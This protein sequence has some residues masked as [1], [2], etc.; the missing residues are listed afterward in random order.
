MTGERSV[1]H[2]AKSGVFLCGGVYT[3]C[4][5]KVCK[6]LREVLFMN[7]IG[8]LCMLCLLKVCKPLEM[9]QC[10]CMKLSTE[11]LRV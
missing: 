8:K 9:S 11:D 6:H 7:V 2:G 5:L 3:H 1:V 4:L 10:L